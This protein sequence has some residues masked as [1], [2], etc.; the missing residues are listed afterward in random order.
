MNKVLVLSP[1]LDDAAFSLGPYLAD[2]SK[3]NKITVATVFT[4]S[5]KDLS[6]FAMACQLDKGLS[7]DVDYMSIRREEDIEWSNRINVKVIHGLLPEAPHRGYN[8]AKEL[9]GSITELPN[10]END[11]NDWFL[12]LLHKTKP[13]AIFCPLGVGS[14]VDHVLVRQTVL[15]QKLSK[16]PIF[17]YKDLPYAEHVSFNLSDYIL[18]DDNWIETNVSLSIES[19]EQAIYAAEAYK[20]QIKF[21]FGS[22]INMISTL[23]RA[24]S[25]ELILFK[26][27]DLNHFDDNLFT[28]MMDRSCLD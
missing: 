10:F 9:F 4:K 8:S 27:K 16:A 6:D 14:H 15:N 12:D 5:E 2:A 11:L 28:R 26:E 18:K 3:K 19:I 22:K 17:L 13:D 25:K 20:T 23:K 21:Q 24:W 1:H 7:C